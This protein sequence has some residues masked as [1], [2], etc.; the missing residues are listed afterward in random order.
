M[1]RSRR[2]IAILV[3]ATLALATP[4]L[5][6]SSVS[7]EESR[8]LSSGVAGFFFFTAHGID[9]NFALIRFEPNNQILVRDGAGL[10]P[11][12]MCRYPNPADRTLVSCSG[13]PGVSFGTATIV[14]GAG[15]DRLVIQA[16]AGLF[17]RTSISAGPGNDVVFGGPGVDTIFGDGGSD[18]LHG[19]GGAD[20]I[21]GESGNDHLYGGPGNDRL[22]GGFGNDVLFGGPGDDFLLGGPGN[23][24]L[25]TGPGRDRWVS[26][27]G[28]N[29]VDGRRER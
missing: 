11:A 18:R 14:L 12:G 22:D 10:E 5:A 17:P 27:G 3:A 8:S 26:G 7:L 19:G 29:F 1:H 13:T 16:A 2:L 25:I 23:D 24:T 15:N 9:R 4:A 21:F 28:I 6:A 20:V